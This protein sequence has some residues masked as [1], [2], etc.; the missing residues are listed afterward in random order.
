MDGAQSTGRRQDMGGEQ[1][2]GRRQLI[3]IPVL[4]TVSREKTVHGLGTVNR[5]KTVSTWI[6]HSQQGEDS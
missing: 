6:E 4:G 2:T 5:E 3:R 1:S